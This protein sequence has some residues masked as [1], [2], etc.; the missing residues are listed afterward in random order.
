MAI[1]KCKEVIIVS[2]ALKKIMNGIRYKNERGRQIDAQRQIE[3]YK[4]IHTKRERDRKKDIYI[5]IYI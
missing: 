3:R 2:K 1:R 5:Y 4:E